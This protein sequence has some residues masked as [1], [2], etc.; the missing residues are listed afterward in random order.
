MRPTVPVFGFVRSF[1]DACCGT[2]SGTPH[3]RWCLFPPPP[4]PAR[5]A[6][7]LPRLRNGDHPH[8]TVP[9]QEYCPMWRLALIMRTP[10]CPG[11]AEAQREQALARWQVLRAHLED[12]VPAGPRGRRARRPER[13]LRRWLA[14][15]RAGGLAAP[16]AAGLART[17]EPGGCRPSLQLLI[18]GLALRRP[19][20]AIATVH[21]QVGRGGPGGGMAGARLRRGVRRG[22]EHRPG[23]GHARARGLQAVQGGVRPGAPPRGRQA[24]P[25]LAGRPHPA[26]PVGAHPV[27]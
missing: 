12:G 17:G 9:E 21:R 14:G 16:G 3:V 20:P 27:G 25:D 8:S 26:G 19:P 22:A 6:V 7:P 10:G 2:T 24:E 1:R 23:D 11:L 5:G 4:A 15:Y 13:T 18:E